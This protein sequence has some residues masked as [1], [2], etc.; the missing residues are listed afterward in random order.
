MNCY[1]LK[2]LINLSQRSVIFMRL[3]LKKKII[4]LFL[5]AMILTVAFF[6]FYFYRSTRE[7]LSESEHNLEVIVTNSIAQEIQDNLDYTE[8]NVRTVVENPKV[9]ELFA[10]R[11]RTVLY[12]Y[13]R[14]TYDSMKDQFPQGHFHLPDS[15]SFLRLNKP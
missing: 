1:D 15:T 13:L 6:A 12:E 14:P 4:L 7:L 9:Q 10:N 5:L 8:A 3:S 11:D 2:Y